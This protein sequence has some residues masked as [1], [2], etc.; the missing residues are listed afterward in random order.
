M[1]A[2]QEII[3][4]NTFKNLFLQKY[5]EEAFN[6]KKKRHRSFTF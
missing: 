1:Q 6:G 3:W 2:T 4:F 5:F